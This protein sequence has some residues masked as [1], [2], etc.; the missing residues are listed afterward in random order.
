MRRRRRPPAL[1]EQVRRFVASTSATPA[2]PEAR[3]SFAQVRWATAAA[4]VG[5]WFGPTPTAR[6]VYLLTITGVSLSD[7]AVYAGRVV[8]GKVGLAPSPHEQQATLVAVA[9]APYDQLTLLADPHS[10]PPIAADGPTGQFSVAPGCLPQDV[11][12]AGVGILDA[13]VAQTADE[14]LAAWL[15]ASPD[16]PPRPD[17]RSGPT[18]GATPSQHLTRYTNTTYDHPGGYGYSSVDVQH[19]DQVVGHITTADQWF[20]EGACVGGA[21][22]PTRGSLPP[23]ASTTSIPVTPT[24]VPPASTT[25]TS[26]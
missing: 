7:E 25:S 1:V 20:V 21:S 16:Q 11:W 3:V 23:S 19:I 5:G 14:A 13:P 6:D 12:C 2:T 17:W 24:T 18:P 10:S 4:V 22:T 8:H 26:G 15:S 9:Q